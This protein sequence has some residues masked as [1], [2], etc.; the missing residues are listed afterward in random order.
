MVASYVTLQ[1]PYALLPPLACGTWH[2]L[3]NRRRQDQSRIPCS[4]K[5]HTDRTVSASRCTRR[6]LS[7]G[8]A[9]DRGAGR[10]CPCAK[11]RKKLTCGRAIRARRVPLRSTYNN[12]VSGGVVLQKRGDHAHCPFVV[13]CQRPVALRRVRSHCPSRTH[14]GSS[15]WRGHAEVELSRCWCHLDPFPDRYSQESKK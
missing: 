7:V 11:A 2:F 1:H 6:S 5:L 12:A 9:V 10:F 13:T 14:T 8:R 4:A 15:E 3:E